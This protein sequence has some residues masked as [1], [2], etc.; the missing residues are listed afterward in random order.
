MVDANFPCVGS[1]GL[2]IKEAVQVPAWPEQYAVDFVIQIIPICHMIQSSRAP[3]WKFSPVYVHK[4]Y[5]D[6]RSAPQDYGGCGYHQPQQGVDLPRS[7]SWPISSSGRDR[8]ELGAL[9]RVRG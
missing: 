6:D 2:H 1:A 9:A 5:D 4:V 7:K 3:C 8:A